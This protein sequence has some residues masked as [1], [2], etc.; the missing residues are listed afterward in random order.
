MLWWSAT[1]VSGFYVPPPPVAG[2]QSP[3]PLYL[4][5]IPADVYL[6]CMLGSFVLVFSGCL[7]GLTALKY[8]A[9]FWAGVF[10]LGLVV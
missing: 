10:V 1:Q 9:G 6:I 3:L 7:S 8:V 4:P 2:F 5:I